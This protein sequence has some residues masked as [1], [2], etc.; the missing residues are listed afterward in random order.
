MKQEL[1]ALGVCLLSAVWAQS[2][3]PSGSPISAIHSGDLA[4]VA[5]EVPEKAPERVVTAALHPEELLLDLLE[6]ERWVGISHIVDSAGSSAAS[7]RFPR[8]SRRVSGSPEAILSLKP[9]LVIVSDYTL[10]TTEMLLGNAGVPV[11]RVPTPRSLPDLF[12]EWQRLGELVHRGSE[13]KELVL[14]ARARLERLR[15]SLPPLAALFIQGRYAYAEG[16]LQVDC[17]TYAG[18]TNLLPDDGRGPTPL[19]S[20][21]ELA[22]LEPDLVFLGA[23]IERARELDRREALPGLPRGAFSGRWPR[24][25]LIPASLMSSMSQFALDS[26]ELYVSLVKEQVP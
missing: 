18:L 13:A 7:A 24:V 11:W 25:F 20:E 14:A 1:F 5:L 16:A 4:T 3:G 2:I 10:A 8:S 6:P 22:V 26:C 19:L 9:D 21:E 15:G 12:D 23:P 17:P